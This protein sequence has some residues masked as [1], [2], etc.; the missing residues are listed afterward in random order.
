VVAFVVAVPVG[1]LAFVLG[2]AVTGGL[3]AAA[4]GRASLDVGA[5]AMSADQVPGWLSAVWQFLAAQFVPVETATGPL[6]RD[7]LFY[8][9]PASRAAFLTHT[10]L[11][12]PTWLF[13]VPPVVLVVAGALVV[14]I[15]DRLVGDPPSATTGAFVAVGYWP[16]AVCAAYFGRAAP[17]L[18]GGDLVHR[19]DPE[20]TLALATVYAVGFGVFGG[21]FAKAWS[22]LVGD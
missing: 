16:T 19:L 20:S 4:G 21:G 8:D 12:P 6:A 7:R 9:G 22:A 13:A 10:R 15:A 14:R 3:V 1:A 17:R 11:S 18:L 2:V 5:L